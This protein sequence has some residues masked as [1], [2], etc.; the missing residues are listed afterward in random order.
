MKIKSPLGNFIDTLYS[1]RN[2]ALLHQSKLSKSE[3]STRSTLIDPILS[4]LGW[5][6][7]NPTMIELEKTMPKSRLDYA[8]YNHRSEIHTIIEAKSLGGN[9]GDRNILL[10]LIMYAIASGVNDI[11]LTD[12]VVWEHYAD[13]SPGNVVSSKTLDLTQDNLLDCAT[14]LTQKL[15]AA[16]FWPSDI[17][18]DNEINEQLSK[19]ILD[20]RNEISN[21]KG[22]LLSL[23]QLSEGQKLS[24]DIQ[25][26]NFI[27]LDDLPSNLTG[28]KPPST[29]R[30]PDGTIKDINTWRDI[31]LENCKFAL[32]NNSSI[33]IPLP[34]ASGRKVNIFD[35]K[36]PAKGIAVHKI[37]YQGKDMY[38]YANYSATRCVKNA[39][40]ILDYVDSKLMQYKTAVRF[41]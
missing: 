29:I 20:L 11:F 37:K 18:E 33:P 19:Q 26:T 36:P 34:D 8:L 30:L 3:A 2:S 5:N 24:Q 9:L 16:K 35:T 1:V 21:L 40:Y 4:A 28:K 27:D 22:D 32:A 14:Y 17:S 41:D 13:F 6:L 39:I 12:G 38:I 25:T 10:N 7:T 15:D 23:Q 31:L